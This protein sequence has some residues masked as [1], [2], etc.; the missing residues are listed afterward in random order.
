MTQHNKDFFELFKENSYKLA[1]QP[2]PRT[3]KRLERRLDAHKRKNRYHI[4]WTLGMVAA[5]LGLVVLVGLLSVTYN[6]K[7]N[8]VLAQQ[9]ASPRY[10]EELASNEQ[11]EDINPLTVIE[12]QREFEEKTS[13]FAEG[14]PERKLMPSPMIEFTD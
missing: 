11:G 9:N 10:L 13:Q 14:C 6:S 2:T 8:N 3:W 7:L 12:S 5:V 4:N 1:E